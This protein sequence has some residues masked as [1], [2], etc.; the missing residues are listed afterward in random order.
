MNDIVERVARVLEPVAW[1]IVMRP[2]D[3]VAWAG[4]RTL[5]LERALAV[6]A[7]MSEPTKEMAIA[8]SIAALPDH[9][10]TRTAKDIWHAMVVEAQEP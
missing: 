1:G 8:G 4:L 9:V 6:I 2:P 10:G 3:G 7:A 5:S